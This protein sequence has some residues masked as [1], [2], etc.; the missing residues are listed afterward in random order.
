M[1]AVAVVVVLAASV[2][3]AVRRGAGAEG[4]RDLVDARLTNG[5]L[6]RA[7][8]PRREWIKFLDWV[9]LLR[10]PRGP[11]LLPIFFY[12]LLTSHSW[13]GQYISE[14]LALAQHFLSLFGLYASSRNISFSRI[15]M[16]ITKSVNRKIF[17][18]INDIDFHLSRARQKTRTLRVI[19]YKNVFS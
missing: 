16:V 18:L 19:S 6:C 4:C 10:P 13:C 17:S 2:V 8:L 5:F 1:A 9:T 3:G 11:H 14:R 12:L 15:P 7:N